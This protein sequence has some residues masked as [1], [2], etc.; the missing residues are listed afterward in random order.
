M[1]L[2]AD[3]FFKY[4]LPTIVKPGPIPT[5]LQ[6]TPSLDDDRERVTRAR[7]AA[8]ELFSPKQP[9]TKDVVLQNPS[10]VERLLRKPRILTISPAVPLRQ[11]TVEG[12]VCLKKTEIPGS[13]FDRIRTW[14]KYGMTVPQVAQVYGVA[15]EKIER[16]LRKA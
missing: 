13:Q 5:S 14:V 11:E 3:K 8:E 2:I 7:V 6:T 15:V 12:P 16:I 10:P 1:A 4:S 9:V